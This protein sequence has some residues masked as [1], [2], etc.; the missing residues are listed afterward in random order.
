M[1]KGAP[2]RLSLAAALTALLAVLLPVSGLANQDGGN[3]RNEQRD[4][5]SR[6]EQ[7]PSDHI[8]LRRGDGL[9]DVRYVVLIQTRFI[10]V[11][12][13]F[14]EGLG[15]DYK[16]L[17]R[18]DV[19][20]VPLLGS[21]FERPLQG[22]DLTPENRVGAA[23]RGGDGTLVAVVDEAVDV[24]G[25]EVS[26]VNG[27]GRYVLSM[28][29]QLTLQHALPDLGDIGALGSVQTLIRGTATRQTALVVGGLTEDTDTEADGVPVL[30]DVPVLR[31]LFMGSVHKVEDSELVIL[32]RPSIIT[33]DE[34]EE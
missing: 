33:G 10:H 32:V 19:S 11:T 6:N 17:D 27:K 26:V 12:D 22:G 16:N 4:T 23:Y 18:A 30:A 21:L 24:A 28:A 29:P 31:G 14:S 25:S 34:T 2:A 8:M 15:V 5:Q 20:E 7:Q 9:F 1:R 3:D 13:T